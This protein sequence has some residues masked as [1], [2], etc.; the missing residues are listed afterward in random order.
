MKYQFEAMDCC[1]T[2]VKDVVTA[3][4]QEEAQAIIRQMGYF[5]TGIRPVK[6][7]PPNIVQIREDQTVEEPKVYHYEAMDATGL[8]KRGT[9]SAKS[10][11]DVRYWLRHNGYFV[12][13]ITPTDKRPSKLSIRLRFDGLW[14]GV[15][16]DDDGNI[17]ACFF[18]FLV[19]HYRN[20]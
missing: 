2:T 13:K 18:P 17:Y 15:H 4:S 10:E 3:S 19:I 11:S 8:E 16:W 7:D 6:P 5:I 20:Q 1:G 14:L 12:T 9:M